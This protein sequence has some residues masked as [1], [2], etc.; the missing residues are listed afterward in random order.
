MSKDSP[1]CPLLL[2]FVEEAVRAVGSGSA[3]LKLDPEE[4][5][6]GCPHLTVKVLRDPW[7]PGIPPG[8]KYLSA[9]CLGAICGILGTLA[10]LEWVI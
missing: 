10:L 4:I 7:W 8:L 6:E 3:M 1:S 2:R 5:M 9:A